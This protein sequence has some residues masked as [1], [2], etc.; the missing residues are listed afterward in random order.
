MKKIIIANWKN[1]L[2]VKESIDLSKKIVS[3][4]KN[5]K[6]FSFIIAPSPVALFSVSGVVKKSNILLAGQ[7]VFSAY[8][9]AYTGSVTISDILEA[10]CSYC[11]AGHSERRIYQKESNSQI[12]KKIIWLQKYGIIPVLCIGESKEQYKKGNSFRSVTYKLKKC[13]KGVSKK[14]IILAYE[15]QWAISGFG[16]KMSADISH[17][18]MMHGKIKKSVGKHVPVLYGGSITHNNMTLFLNEPIIDGLLVGRASTR[19]SFYSL[20]KM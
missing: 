16:N 13:L 5:H 9:G 7:N 19:A 11:L 2:S 15:P 8:N 20:M 14:H 18:T 12:N 6:N 17:V 10:G 3:N 1:Y 4:K